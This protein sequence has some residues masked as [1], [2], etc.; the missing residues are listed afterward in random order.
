M[1]SP[2]KGGGLAIRMLALKASLSY[3]T[4]AVGSCFFTKEI[5]HFHSTTVNGS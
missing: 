2:V 4:S 5:R 1:G 3:L